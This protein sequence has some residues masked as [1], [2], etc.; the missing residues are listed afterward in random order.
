MAQVNILSAPTSAYGT[1]ELKLQ[2]NALMTGTLTLVTDNTNNASQLKLSTTL[3]Q[4]AGTLQ[5]AKDGGSYIDAQ[6]TTGIDRFNVNRGS[7]SQQV[8]IDFASLPTDLTTP[9]GA[10]RT[11]TDGVNLANVMTFLENGNIGIRTPTPTATLQVKGS[12]S[13][14]A[15]TSL[16]VQNSAGN[17]ILQSFDDRVTQAFDL[18]ISAENTYNNWGFKMSSGGAGLGYIASDSAAFGMPVGIISLGTRVT[19]AT[20]TID[21]TSNNS[22]ILDVV[23]TT[24][25]FLPPRMTTA[26]KNAI[27]TP[28]AGLMVYDT[29]LNKLCLRTAAAW[30]TITSV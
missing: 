16:L 7:A 22:S 26:Q 10:I 5:I 2:S 17:R 27:A 18:R 4:V 25:G 24:Q 28:T 21:A 20:S 13:T 11:A 19:I 23:S 29:T 3:T 30:E 15:T 14:S 8:N 1:G 9:V 12:G 6:D